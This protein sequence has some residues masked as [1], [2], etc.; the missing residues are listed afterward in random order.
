MAQR[1]HAVYSSALT[2]GVL[3]PQ[4]QAVSLWLPVVAEWPA[5]SVVVAL[6]ISEPPPEPFS[7][8]LEK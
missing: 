3:P 7:P 5:E 6:M 8:Y 4:L 1:E 2:A